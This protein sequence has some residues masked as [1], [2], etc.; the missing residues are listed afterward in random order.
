MIGVAK[1]DYHTISRCKASILRG[2]SRKPLFVT[3]AGIPLDQAA[4]NIKSMHGQYRIPTLLKELDR[5]TKS[6]D[7]SEGSSATGLVP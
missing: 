2:A 4:E 7:S 1:T 5:L 6:G 3:A